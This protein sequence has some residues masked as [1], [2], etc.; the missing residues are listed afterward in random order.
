MF[1]H[2]TYVLSYPLEFKVPWLDLWVASPILKTRQNEHQKVSS[3]S[4]TTILNMLSII[5]E[6]RYTRDTLENTS[7]VPRY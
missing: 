4:K 2:V 5:Q 1:I 3:L 6:P 7:A